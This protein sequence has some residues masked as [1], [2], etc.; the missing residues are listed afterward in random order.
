MIGQ[1]P[2]MPCLGLAFCDFRP[3]RNHQ[4]VG[5]APRDLQVNISQQV[6][7][8]FEWFVITNYFCV[9][10]AAIYRNVDS[11]DYISHLIVL[12]T[13][14]YSVRRKNLEEPTIPAAFAVSV[15]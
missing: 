8:I 7:K 12:Y 4:L 2:S 5:F 6:R 15:K 9:V 13:N 11:E 1:I 14:L 10:A 3:I